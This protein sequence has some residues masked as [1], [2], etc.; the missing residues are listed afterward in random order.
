MS[1]GQLQKS[2]SPAVV[3]DLKI[4]HSGGLESKWWYLDCQKHPQ[5]GGCSQTGVEKSQYHM[6]YQ[7]RKSQAKPAKFQ[8]VLSSWLLNVFLKLSQW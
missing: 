7:L 2:L 8:L 3:Q 6:L 1:T 5:I 4:L